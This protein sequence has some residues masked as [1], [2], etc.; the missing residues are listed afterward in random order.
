M[1]KFIIILF[2]TLSLNANIISSDFPSSLVTNNFVKT[3]IYEAWYDGAT[4]RYDH[5]VLGD[6]IEASILRFKIKNKDCI[7][8]ASLTLDKSLVFEDLNPRLKDINNDG[9]LEIIVIQSHQ[10]LGARIVVY[11]LNHAN[12]LEEFVSTPFIGKRYRWLAISAIADINKDGFMDIVYIDR[13]HLANI[14]RVWTYK[15]NDFYELA[16]I[17]GLSNHRIG[18]NFISGGIKSCKGEIEIITA[19]GD[20]SHIMSTK[21]I[22]KKLQSVKVAPFKNTDDFNTIL[23]C[24]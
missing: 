3:G 22:E 14:L 7:Y 16:S 1:Q 4:S 5:G 18:N 8:S 10:N 15:N 17:R 2:F 12:K 11:K 6:E 23:S 13:P 24:K 19:N 9:N 20:W 21:F